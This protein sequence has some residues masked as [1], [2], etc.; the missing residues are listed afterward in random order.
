MTSF[1]YFTCL[2]SQTDWGLTYKVFPHIFSL[3]YFNYP[4]LYLLVLP[5]LWNKAVI[6]AG[7]YFRWG[8]NVKHVLRME[9]LLLKTSLESSRELRRGE[10]TEKWLVSSASTLSLFCQ[11]FESWVPPHVPQSPAACLQMQLCDKNKFF[12]LNRSWL[13]GQ[14][15]LS[16]EK[17]GKG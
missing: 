15:W 3:M 8:W 10:K 7:S 13:R 16:Q 2:F 14:K 9:E 1:M 6:S 4:C 17:Q 12:S 11:H 5:C